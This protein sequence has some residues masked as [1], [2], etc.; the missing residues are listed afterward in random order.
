L[1]WFRRRKKNPTSRLLR[2]RTCSP[3]SIRPHVIERAPATAPRRQSIPRSPSAAAVPAVGRAQKAR[4]STAAEPAQTAATK[5]A[6]K[7]QAT[8]PRR[9]AAGAQGRLPAARS[10]AGRRAVVV[11]ARHRAGRHCPRQARVDRLGRRRRAARP[12][13]SRRQG[14][15]GHLERR[16]G[17]RSPG[18][19]P[20]PGRQR[21][22]GQWRPLSSRSASRRNGFPT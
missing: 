16:S 3:G 9:K 7:P 14:R 12:P 8:K 2:C 4:C 22:S 15:R 11:A 5:S 1:P 13:C 20:R 6:G 21:A 10:G 17:A 19:L 18:T